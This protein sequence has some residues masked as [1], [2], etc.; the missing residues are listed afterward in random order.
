M[1]NRVPA[2]INEASYRNAIKVPDNAIPW[3]KRG[4]ITAVPTGTVAT[5]IPA[6]LVPSNVKGLRIAGLVY[7]SG[8]NHANSTFKFMKD[9]NPYD[10]TLGFLQLGAVVAPILIPVCAI[11]DAGQTFELDVSNISGSNKDYGAYAF[12]WLFESF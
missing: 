9:G 1:I 8:T 6:Y 5:I 10:D 2:I 7:S 12:G 11:Y 3:H 4:F